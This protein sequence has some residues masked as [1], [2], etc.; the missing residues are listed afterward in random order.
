[1]VNIHYLASQTSLVSSSMLVQR[2]IEDAYNPAISGDGNRIVWT[3][4]NQIFLYDRKLNSRMLVSS[5]DGVTPAAN[6]AQ[7]AQISQNGRY[8]VFTSHSTNLVN[9]SSGLQVFIK[10]LD[11]ITAPPKLVSSIDSTQADQTAY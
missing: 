3:H 4:S 6:G 7:K 9:G 10:D 1:K 8:V 11:N 2:A 5:P